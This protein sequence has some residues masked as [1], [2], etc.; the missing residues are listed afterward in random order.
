MA[1]R[2]SESDENSRL[3]IGARGIP[4]SRPHESASLW[5][6]PRRLRRGRGQRAARRRGALPVGPTE[7]RRPGRG[8]RALGTTTNVGDSGCLPGAAH[9]AGGVFL[10]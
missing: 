4:G 2:A 9:L 3:S 7:S 1:Q 10:S 8:A 6:G 5:A